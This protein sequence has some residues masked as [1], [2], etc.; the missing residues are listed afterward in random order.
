LT[1]NQAAGPYTLTASFAGDSFYVPSLVATPFTINLEETTT[2]FTAS[3]ATVIP[4][5]HS[6]TLS[7]TLLEDGT[8]PPVPFGQTIT[9]TLGTGVTAQSCNGTTNASGL[10]TCTIATVS[11]PLGPNTVTAKFAGDA[12]Y[13]PSSASEAVILFAFLSQGSMIVGNLDAA[14]GTA[15]DYWGAQWAKDNSLSG[16][17]APNSFKGFAETAPQTCGGGWISSPGN[18]SGPPATVPS[19]MG[20]IASSTIGKSGSSISGDVPIII[21]VKTAPGYGPS[22]GHEGTGTVVAVYCH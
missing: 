16:G 10:A 2:T 11:Q 14:T 17:S 13:Q 8:T 22:P 1:P 7:A 15:V 3:S 19:Y 4:V 6:A 5:G 21:V 12:F 9:L 20:V 18:S